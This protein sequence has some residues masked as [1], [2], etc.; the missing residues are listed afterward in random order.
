MKIPK[1]SQIDAMTHCFF[2]DNLCR[3]EH[4][5]ATPKYT[6]SMKKGKFKLFKKKKIFYVCH[7]CHTIFDIKT[8]MF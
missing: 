5:V 6:V 7:K 4:L 8:D 2:Q 3:H 1:P